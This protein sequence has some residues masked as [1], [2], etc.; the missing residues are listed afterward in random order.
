M[1]YKEKLEGNKENQEYMLEKKERLIQTYI[2]MYGLLLAC[3]QNFDEVTQVISLCILIRFLVCAITYYTAITIKDDKVKISFIKLVPRIEAIKSSA[4]ATSKTFGLAI[5]I[6]LSK[7]VFSLFKVHNVP[8]LS[9][10]VVVVLYLI[11]FIP[12]KLIHLIREAFTIVEVLRK[13][14]TKIKVLRK[15][16]TIIEALR[17][18]F[19]KIEVLR[20]EHL[21]LF[22]LIL[23]C[24]YCVLA[25]L[26][27]TFLQIPPVFFL[28]NI[29]LALS[30]I[31][32]ADTMAKSLKIN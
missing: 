29:A 19:T 6:Y 22:L 12:N 17:K 5:I 14:F 7:A 21:V 10:W 30:G 13:K 23:F 4:E 18:V 20:K 3:T 28:I 32:L 25:I 15:V 1:S 9:S 2:V 27:Q 24:T 8:R 16:F 31:F 26:I 11:F